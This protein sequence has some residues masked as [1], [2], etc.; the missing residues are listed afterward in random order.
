MVVSNLRQR[1]EFSIL[2][3]YR[4]KNLLKKI[5]KKNIRKKILSGTKNSPLNVKKR[6]PRYGSFYLRVGA[7]AFGIGSMVYSGLEFGQYF[8]LKSKYKLK[9]K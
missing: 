2:D 6:G 1:A 3:K 8:E 5:K 4:K 9:I 7:I